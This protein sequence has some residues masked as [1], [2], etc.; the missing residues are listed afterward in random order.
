ME[1]A[2]DAYKALI[3]CPGCTDD[4]YKAASDLHEKCKAANLKISQMCKAHDI[5]CVKY[6]NDLS[7]YKKKNARII[8]QA[9]AEFIRSGD[10]LLREDTEFVAMECKE[11]L[12]SIL[13]DLPDKVLAEDMHQEYFKKLV[14]NMIRL[15]LKFNI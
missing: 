11:C 3:G 12:E 7:D 2:V 9:R 1:P 10:L 4:R 5:D 8:Q 15:G 14:K 13:Q 6:R